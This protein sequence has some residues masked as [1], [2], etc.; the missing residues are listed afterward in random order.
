MASDIIPVPQSADDAWKLLLGTWILLSLGGGGTMTV[1]LL[2]PDQ[3]LIEEGPVHTRV[4]EA[5]DSR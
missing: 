5:S 3:L 1:R 4:K 2:A